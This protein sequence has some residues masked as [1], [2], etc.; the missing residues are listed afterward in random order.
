MTDSMG[1]SGGCQDLYTVYPTTNNQTCQSFA[2]RAQV[3]GMKAIS[4]AT[5]STVS[6]WGWPASCTD[7]ELEPIDDASSGGIK[8]T[9]PYTLTVVP[10][11]RPPLNITF[12]KLLFLSVASLTV[13]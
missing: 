2:P 11:L 10:G 7:L 13:V 5:Q 12:G 3:L 9:P 1:I 6:R 4:S 8:G